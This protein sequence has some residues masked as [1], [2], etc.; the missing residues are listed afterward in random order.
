MCPARLSHTSS[1]Y[2][3]RGIRRRKMSGNRRD[4]LKK[5]LFGTTVMGSASLVQGE[6]KPA[7]NPFSDDPVAM[8]KLTD[9]VSATR[10]GLGTGMR[11]HNQESD[12]TRLGHDKAVELIRYCY[13][14]GVRLFDMA[15][16]Y[17]T[18]RFVGEALRDKPRDSYTLV[19]K[20][21]P[22]PG[23]VPDE[24]KADAKTSVE[25]FLKEIGTDY[26]DVLQIHCMS[27][28]NWAEEFA[29]LCD[30]LSEL[31]ERG[32]IR[33]HGI[34]CHGIEAVRAGAV[35]DWVDTMHVRLNTTGA[36]MD[37]TLEENLEVNK[38]AHDN[39]KGIIVMK[40]LGE[41]SITDPAEQK[42]SIRLVTCCESTDVMVVGF[43]AMEQVD[44]FLDNVKEALTTQA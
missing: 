5:T 8:R 2:A 31:K 39:G 34:S 32:L 26:I 36:R 10:V 23:G 30:G 38:K 15:D 20:I 18:H 3:Q 21:W 1:E 33:A 14:K 25:R 28:P 6:E 22:H 40:V 19:S 35:D 11:G 27:A 29:E 37:G 42:R 24:C 4:F 17:G 7:K 9:T 44:I 43:T 16:L 12:L 41:G 13:D